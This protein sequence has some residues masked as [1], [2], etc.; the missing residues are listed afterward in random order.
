M[1]DRTRFAL[2]LLADGEMPALPPGHQ[3]GL[4]VPKGGSSCA[5]CRY[6][7]PQGG[8]Y[9]TCESSYYQASVGTALIPMPADEWCSDMYEPRAG[10]LED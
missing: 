9:G 4:R 6:Y 7:N 8:R 10:A 2:P 1:I 5:S 3:V